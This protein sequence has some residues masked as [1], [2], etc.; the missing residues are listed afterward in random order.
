MYIVF[1]K[2]EKMTHFK[3]THTE[4]GTTDSF[5]GDDKRIVVINAYKKWVDAK[6]INPASKDFT[7]TKIAK[8]K[9]STKANKEYTCSCC[10]SK[11]LK[12]DSYFSKAVRLGSSKV[13]QQSYLMDIPSL[14]R[15]VSSV[16]QINN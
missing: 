7:A 5:K 11:I 9:K 6:L 15:F 14:I 13:S 3:V 2:G 10:S 12:G 16:K 1:R 8:A 4:T